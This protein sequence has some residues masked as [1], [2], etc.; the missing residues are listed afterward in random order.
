MSWPG[1]GAEDWQ[2][3]S[4]SFSAYFVN[5]ECVNSVSFVWIKEISEWDRKSVY[6]GDTVLCIFTDV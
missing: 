4:L 3:D 2:S 6:C 1:E 5:D